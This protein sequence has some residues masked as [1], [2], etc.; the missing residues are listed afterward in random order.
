MSC[1]VPFL[2]LSRQSRPLENSIVAALREVVLSGHFVLGPKIEQFEE[3]LACYSEVNHAVACA[4]G[5]EALLMALMA[6]GIQPGDEVITPSFTFFATASAIA[7]LGATPVFADIVPETFHLNPEDVAAKVTPRTRAIL[8]VHLFGQAVEMEPFAALSRQ[9]AIPLVE[10]V[11]QAIGAE[12][13]WQGETRRAGSMG[14]VNCFS[15]YPTKNLG[16]M[17]DAGALTTQD[18]AMAE[19]LRLIRGHGMEPRYFHKMIGINGRLDAFQGTVLNI[20]FPYLETWIAARQAIALRYAE[21][22]RDAGLDA[23]IT[24][25]QIPTQGRHVW[26]QYCV[27][28][29]RGYRDQLRSFLRERG[30]GSEI[31]YPLGLHE[32]ECFRYL[33]WRLG[34]LPVTEH[35]S[36]EILALPIFPGLTEEEQ[37]SVVQ[38]IVAFFCKKY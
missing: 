35:I 7:R 22:F 23:E 4:S 32:Q 36:R 6:L 11:A 20:K 34:M 30:I 33:G 25:P 27:R 9:H 2:D 19:K 1:S 24:L 21:L 37:E 28:I 18:A 14:R 17:G 5:S 12:T 8:V 29:H 13:L 31:Y 10:D 26:N 15:F 16:A 3:T 38:Q